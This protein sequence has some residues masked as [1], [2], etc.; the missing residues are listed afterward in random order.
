ML[1]WWDGTAWTDHTS[2]IPASQ[3]VGP[4]GRPIAARRNLRRW[5]LATRILVGFVGLL[6]LA[7]VPLAMGARS[8]VRR[9]DAGEI[10]AD[11]LIAAED[12]LFSLGNV[13]VVIFYLA[14]TCW[15]VWLFQALAYPSAAGRMR[16]D[17]ARG[18]AIGG[19]I[20]PIAS[21]T[22]PKKLHDQ[23]WRHSD[24][25]AYHATPPA[26]TGWWW[27]AFLAMVLSTQV[28]PLIN[29]QELDAFVFQYAVIAMLSCF[30]V[31]AAVLAIKMLGMFDARV[32]RFAATQG[33]PELS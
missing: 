20:V 11:A 4:K 18:W 25:E 10:D 22:I 26:I 14:A 29:P 8:A 5:N 17:R 23:L 28:V 32:D 13:R 2:P 1:R 15:V 33:F 21:F 7:A 3:P 24:T 30:G 31:V 16:G 27:F 9:F 12:T 19:W 6:D